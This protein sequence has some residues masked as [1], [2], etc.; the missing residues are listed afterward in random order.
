MPFHPRV[1]GVKPNVPKKK[2]KTS[3][4]EFKERADMKERRKMTEISK[5]LQGGKAPVEP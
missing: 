5:G 3:R 4:Q 1:V 2:K